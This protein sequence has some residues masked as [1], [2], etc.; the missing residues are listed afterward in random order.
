MGWE[1]L[2]RIQSE[3]IPLQ[4]GEKSEAMKMDL[5]RHSA[6]FHNGSG[7]LV[8]RWTLRKNR[9]RGSLLRR[10]CVCGKKQLGDLIWTFTQSQIKKKLVRYLMLLGVEEAEGCTFKAI[11]AGKAMQMAA[12]GFTLGDI[13]DARGWKAPTSV[14]QYVRDDVADSMEL[15]R[16]MLEMDEEGEDVEISADAEE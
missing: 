12:H 3:C 4:R 5:Q 1:F 16:H 14:L 6:V 7:N 10:Q 8:V 2:K 11:R 13:C 9:P 15:L